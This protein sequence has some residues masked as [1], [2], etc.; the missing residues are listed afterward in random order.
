ML[1]SRLSPTSIESNRDS[2]TLAAQCCLKVFH[3]TRSSK[4]SEE[5]QREEEHNFDFVVK[6]EAFFLSR[7][8]AND[9]G[10][11]HKYGTLRHTLGRKV[12]AKQNGNKVFL[13]TT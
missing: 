10:T 5:K 1:S 12:K 13:H 6:A 11:E 8:A 4:P 7:S 3:P 2:A 9:D